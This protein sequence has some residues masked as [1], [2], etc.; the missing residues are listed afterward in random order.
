MACCPDTF[1]GQRQIYQIRQI[2]DHRSLW[3]NEGGSQS[4]AVVN[5]CCDLSADPTRR[6]IGTAGAALV[7]GAWAGLGRLLFT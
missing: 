2:S 1:H 5:A 3:K 7:A 6:T 4:V